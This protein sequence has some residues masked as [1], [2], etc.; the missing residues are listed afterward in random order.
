MKEK[1]N[2]KLINGTFTPSEASR[3]LFDL[4]SSKINYHTMENF[5]NQEKFGKDAPHSERRI[6]ALQKAH[7][8]LKEIFESA[9]KKKLKLKIDGSV[10]ITITE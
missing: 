1:Y 5:S 4:I 6:K 7:T 10:E 8:S 2:F 9:A 3:I